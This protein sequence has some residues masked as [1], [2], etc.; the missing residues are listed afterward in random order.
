MYR[1]GSRNGL[2]RHERHSF[3]A[4]PLPQQTPREPPRPLHP[5]ICIHLCNSYQP[6]KKHLWPLAPCLLINKACLDSSPWQPAYPCS[7]IYRVYLSIPVYVQKDAERHFTCIL[8]LKT[9]S[10]AST[11]ARRPLASRCGVTLRS[12]SIRSSQVRFYLYS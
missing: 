12:A 2:E 4:P 5:P 3:G 6:I 11:E 1:L 9:G 7:N 8:N 10:S